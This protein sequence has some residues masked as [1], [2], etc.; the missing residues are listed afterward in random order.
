MDEEEEEFH[1][2]PMPDRGILSASWILKAVLH[3]STPT[4][5]WR[6][7]SGLSHILSQAHDDERFHPDEI[8]DIIVQN[9]FTGRYVNPFA[10]LSEE[11]ETNITE[12][13]IK[14]FMESLDFLDE[15]WYTESDDKGQ[16]KGTEDD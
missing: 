6:G 14:V 11:N 2:H 3:S 9:M 12:D 8:V 13:E 10:Y 15:G 7:L 4:M 16:E 5:W 1:E